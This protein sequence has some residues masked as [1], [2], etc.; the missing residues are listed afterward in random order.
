MRV[1]RPRP[2]RLSSSWKGLHVHNKLNKNSRLGHDFL[3]AITARRQTHTTRPRDS[4]ACRIFEYSQFDGSQQFQPQSADKLFDQLAEYMMQYGDRVMRQL[5]DV[6]DPDQQ[7]VVDLLQ[8]EGL[9]E[10]DGEGKY[11][12]APKGLRRI[13][14]GALHDLFQVFKRD[15]V[16]KH[17]T[18]QKGGRHGQP[19]GYQAL[20]VRRLAGA[21]EPARDA[22][23][24][25]DPA[26]GQRCP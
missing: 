6:D 3:Q 9:I 24:R 14:E 22:Q 17:D 5:D 12:V 13:Q 16:G 21:S 8:K 11:R 7:D 19:G 10:K 2:R 25:H 18:P 20:R 1:R 26:G 23:E 15:G 4:P